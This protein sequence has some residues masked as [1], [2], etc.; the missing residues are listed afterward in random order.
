M[1][2]HLHSVSNVGVIASV[3]PSLISHKSNDSC[4]HT[5]LVHVYAVLC[6]ARLMLYVV[7]AVSSEASGLLAAGT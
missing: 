2:E 6:W 4:L 1:R 7:P 3:A 5:D